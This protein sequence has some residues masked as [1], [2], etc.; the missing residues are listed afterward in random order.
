MNND[1]S[2]KNKDASSICTIYFDGGCPVCSREIATYQS[3]RG[4][5][6]IKWVDASRCAEEDFGTE[7][8]RTQALNK[9]HARDE[10]G[11]LVSGAAAFIVMWRQL[12]ALKWIT[13]ALERP[14]MISILDAMYHLFLRYRPRWRKPN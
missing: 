10:S 12:P 13:P 8:D 3:W 5:D 14:W 7:L 6:K 11:M 4:A 2:V 9:L 1:I